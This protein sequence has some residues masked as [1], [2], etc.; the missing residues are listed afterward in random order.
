MK[1]LTSFWQYMKATS[2]RVNMLERDFKYTTD[3]TKRKRI[4]D[5]IT[6]EKQNLHSKLVEFEK[7]LA[8]SNQIDELRYDTL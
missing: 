8:H 1:E 4:L 3:P 2:A 6:W 7:V 5:S